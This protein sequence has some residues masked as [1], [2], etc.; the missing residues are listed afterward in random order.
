MA[1]ARLSKVTAKFVHE[2]S[3]KNKEAYSEYEPTWVI[4]NLYINSFV[5]RQEFGEIPQKLEITITRTS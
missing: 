5:L 4:G 2:K 3:T 1:E